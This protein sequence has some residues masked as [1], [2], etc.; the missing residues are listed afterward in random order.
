[1]RTTLEVIGIILVIN[2]LGGLVSDGFGLFVHVAD[3]GALT[4]LRVGALLVGAILI[5]G[6]LM[7]RRAEKAA[8]SS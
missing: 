2:G 5:V 3:G 4:A 8:D 7:S 1:M 6:C